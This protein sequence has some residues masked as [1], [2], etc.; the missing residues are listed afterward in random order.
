MR[1]RRGRKWRPGAGGSSSFQLCGESYGRVVDDAATHDFTPF[2]PT[3]VHSPLMALSLRREF[4]NANPRSVTPTTSPHASPPTR[5]LDDDV[6][7]ADDTE[8]AWVDEDEE[9]DDDDDD[10]DPN[11]GDEDL[12][13]DLD[14]VM[15]EDDDLL[16][17]D[18]D[19]DTE[20]D[21]D[22]APEAGDIDLDAEIPEGDADGG[23]E[24]TDTE[25]EDESSFDVGYGAD[26]VLGRSVW[27]QGGEGVGGR[28]GGGVGSGVAAGGAGA[29][30]GAANL[31][32]GSV[33]VGGSEGVIRAA[34]RGEERRHVVAGNAAGGRRS[35]RGAG[36]GGGGGGGA[37]GGRGEASQ[38][39]T[40]DR[41]LERDRDRE[42]GRG[43]EN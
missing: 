19:A 18:E 2:T 7:N 1:G 14:N 4:T 24:H 23:Y 21:G 15:D 10:D 42:R 41:H 36:G 16:P 34:I 39:S 13:L 12:D 22:Y 17:R 37:G 25:I 5:D 11:V 6:P 9:D 29:G 43:P 33:G 31:R 40:M 30:E 32:R 35:S 8:T 27:G 20:G 28:I 26:G 3:Q 38:R